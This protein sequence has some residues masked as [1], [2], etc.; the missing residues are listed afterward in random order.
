MENRNEEITATSERMIMSDEMNKDF[1]TYICPK[2]KK[3]IPIDQDVCMY[4]YTGK[5]SKE[6]GCGEGYKKAI[7]IAVSENAKMFWDMVI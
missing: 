1:E 5:V 2:C 4:G 3:E 7:L 6:H